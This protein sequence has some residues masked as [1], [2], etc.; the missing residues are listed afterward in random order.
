VAGPYDLGT[1]VIRQ[2][3]QINP[4]TAQ[5][6][7]VSDPFPTILQGIPLQ[8][9]SVSVTMNRP[10]F[11]VNPTS[12]DVMAVTGTPTS[13]GGM[14]APESSRFQVGG[15]AALPFSPKLK[16]V[17]S[18]KGKTK[19]GDHPTLTSTL[20]QT[21]GQANISKVRV[22]LPLNF[23]LD[24]NNSQHVCS[25]QIAQAVTTGPADCPASTLIGHATAI[26]PLLSKPLTGPVYL[27]QGIRMSHGVQIH[28]LPSL[29]IP[30]RGQIALD[31]R[32]QTSVS[33]GKLVTTFPT[34]PDA[35]VSKFTLTING[36]KKGILV[37]TGRGRNI[38][39]GPQI[40]DATL[41]AQS[42]KATNPNIKMSTPCKTP[43]KIKHHSKKHS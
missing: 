32:A 30:L 9:K 38:C 28:T 5:A 37:I 41:T 18:G 11:T 24:P 10:D 12:C 17:L 22:A 31:L 21:G 33:G 16:M 4:S 29:L 27:V 20:T 40:T 3:L 8:I 34:I 14:S 1:V 43:H 39:T 42:G 35:A 13:T 23:A 6:T 2:Q 7:V 15:C 25:Y 36:G 19:S 26:T